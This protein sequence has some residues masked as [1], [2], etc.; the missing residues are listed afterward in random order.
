MR[1]VDSR[2]IHRAKYAVGRIGSHSYIPEKIAIARLT[3]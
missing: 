3:T 1:Q 2:C